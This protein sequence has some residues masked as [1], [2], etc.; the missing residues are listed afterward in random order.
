MTIILKLVE[1]QNSQFAI[2][3]KNGFGNY[4]EFSEI[5]TDY[6]SDAD[7]CGTWSLLLKSGKYCFVPTQERGETELNKV[8]EALMTKYKKIRIVRTIKTLKVKQ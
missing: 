5:S 2:M 8:Y 4:W 7:Y 1:L 3:R 6:K